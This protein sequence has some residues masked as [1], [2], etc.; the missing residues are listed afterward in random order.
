ML[1]ELVANRLL[2]VS[3][4]C[5]ELLHAVDHIIDQV[6]TVEI[7]QYEPDSW[8]RRADGKYLPDTR[9]SA[10]MAHEG[11]TIGALDPSTKFYGGI[12][13]FLRSV[14]GVQQGSRAARTISEVGPAHTSVM[15]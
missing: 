5:T 11:V 1:D 6:E 12:L 14:T 2:G 4:P 15:L 8:T 10:H 3:G 7:V 13:G 9:I